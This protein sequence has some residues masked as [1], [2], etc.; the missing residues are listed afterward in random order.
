MMRIKFFKD[1]ECRECGRPVE[2]FSHCPWCGAWVGNV[3]R[4]FQPV[5]FFRQAGKLIVLFSAI[6]LLHAYFPIATRT[7]FHTFA[8]LL[9]AYIILAS[10][11]LPPIPAAT[12]AGRAL[13]LLKNTIPAIVLC[14]VV[15]WCV[16]H[17]IFNN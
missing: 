9:I 4:A 15:Y 5:V 7:L 2:V 8:P 17:F 3:R 10:A 14:A 1:V 11:A 6:Y 13:Q 12:R 16:E